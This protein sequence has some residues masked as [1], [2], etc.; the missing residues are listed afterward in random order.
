MLELSCWEGI[1]PRSD[2]TLGNLRF[3]RRL[4]DGRADSQ[5]KTYTSGFP[6]GECR[7]EVRLSSAP[8]GLCE[9]RGG[10]A[11]YPGIWKPLGVVGR[12]LGAYRTLAL[13]LVGF[14]TVDK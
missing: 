12:H 3:S 4:S 11:G 14:V 2:G 13:L 6:V 5:T 7:R 10:E 8:R 9:F 1:K